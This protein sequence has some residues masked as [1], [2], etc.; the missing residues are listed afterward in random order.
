MLNPAALTNGRAPTS[1]VTKTTPARNSA[2]HSR[3]G[4]N[5]TATILSAYDLP[6]REPPSYVTIHLKEN[7]KVSV[8]TGPPAQ[9]H[10][11]RN[12][13]KFNRET[14][15]LRTPTLPE[16]YS[17]TA[18]VTVAYPNHNTFIRAEYSLDQLKIHE[19]VWLI[20]QLEGTF[21]ADEMV[22]PTIRLQFTLSGP[23]RPEIGFFVNLFEGWYK[24]V[25]LM[26]DGVSDQT[27]KLPSLD[28]MVR[29]DPKFY[30][31]PAVPAVAALVVFAPVIAGA[32]AVTL[33]LA[34]PVLVAAGGIL[35]ILLFLGC[36]LYGS[37]RSGRAQM[38]SVFAP[39]FNTVV[40]TKVG[41][42]ALY[43]TGPRPTPVSLARLLMPQGIWGKL[44]VSLLID[45]AGSAS[46]L[47]PVVG[48]VTDLGWAPIQTVLIMALYEDQQNKMEGQNPEWLKYVSFAEEILPFTDIVPTA[49]MGW[50]MYTG[51]PHFLG[52]DMPATN[53]TSTKSV[54]TLRNTTTVPPTQFQS[55]RVVA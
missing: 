50:L 48:E 54:P 38:G 43:Q 12:S 31:V 16:L 13:F 19:T 25:D 6:L 55:T 3:E 8:K 40:S 52:K 51:M 44:I 18:V 39:I 5:L 41:Q 42:T 10:K 20:L 36:F 17:S 2:S 21:D 34:L 14:V 9:R 33:P 37:T 32:I 46:Y 53:T 11:D 1:V 29:M 27:K 26:E 7:E 23:Y 24:F 4:G 30:L 35:G 28:W 49:T 47:V 15:T 22:P 45:G